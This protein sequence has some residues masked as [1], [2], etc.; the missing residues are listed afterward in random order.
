MQCLRTKRRVRMVMCVKTQ[1]AN[2]RKK[3]KNQII[4]VTV[5]KFG[6]RKRLICINKKKTE[7]VEKDDSPKIDPKK[8]I[9]ECSNVNCP[10]RFT[11][12]KAAKSHQLT[13]CK[14][15]VENRNLALLGG[16]PF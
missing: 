4:N 3:T 2:S 12:K 10:K 7:Y 15:R 8:K 6:I 13:S 5:K 16:N 14:N 9:F 11:T 1:I